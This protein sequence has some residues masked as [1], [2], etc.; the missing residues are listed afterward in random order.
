[1]QS[2]LQGLPVAGMEAPYDL[3]ARGLRRWQWDDAGCTQDFADALRHLWPV[4]CDRS[5]SIDQ[6]VY[7]VEL[8]NAVIRDLITSSQEFESFDYQ[9]GIVSPSCNGPQLVMPVEYRGFTWTR[10]EYRCFVPLK[11]YSS[12]L[13]AK[14]CAGIG[15]PLLAFHNGSRY[16]VDSEAP[17]S[18]TAVVVP[19]PHDGVLSLAIVNPLDATTMQT[20]LGSASEC[21]ALTVSR[22]TAA[23][24]AFI[25]DIDPSAWIEGLV[26]PGRVASKSGLYMPQPHERGK[27]PVIVIHGLVSDPVTWVAMVNELQVDPLIQERFEFW[28]YYYPT[29][30]PFPLEAAKLRRQLR[31]ARVYVDPQQLDSA[32]DQM[33]LVGHSMGGLVAKLQVTSSG[34]AVA[35]SIGYTPARLAASPPEIKESLVWSPVASVRRVVFMATPHRGSEIASRPVGRMASGMVRLDGTSLS[36]LVD[37]S[38]GVRR[39]ENQEIPTSIDLLEPTNPTLLSIASLPVSPCVAAH[40]IIGMGRGG[41]VCPPG[42][43]VVPIS[44]ARIPGVESEFYVESGHDVHQRPAAIHE[45]RRILLQHAAQSVECIP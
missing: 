17:F 3:Y 11:S 32:L 40:S 2:V 30:T 29:G 26:L 13:S 1:M 5:H 15:V 20:V 14:S 43:G 34:Y 18:A 9:S 4:I 7:A 37:N 38:L 16:F 25:R 36:Q 33:V 10:Q 8:Y 28:A 35:N 19:R 39:D 6:R 45:V 31:E 42:D 41:V 12:K 23:P 27:I 24:L 44:S 21:C 22:D